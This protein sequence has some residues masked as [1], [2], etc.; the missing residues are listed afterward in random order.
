MGFNSGFK[1]LRLREFQSP[2]FPR[3]STHEDG[4]VVSPTHMPPLPLADI[5]GTYL[6]WS[7]RRS[8]RRSAAGR[9]KTMKNLSDH[10]EN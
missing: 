10:I 8:Q 9:I 7:L 6:C 3:Q 5:S 4:K 2:R 1:G